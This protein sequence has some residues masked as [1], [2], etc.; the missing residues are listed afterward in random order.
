[1]A[2]GLLAPFEKSLQ[3][4]A[5]R[6]LVRRGVEVRLSTEIRE[7]TRDCVVLAS[8]EKVPSDVTIWAAGVAA[9][10]VAGRWGLPQGRGGR[11]LTGPD[12]RVHG[13]PRVFAAGDIA[14][15]AGLALPQLA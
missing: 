14:P 13:Q 2:P 15:V 1:M 4:Y 11:I 12:L 9:P 10:T 7:V 5:R 6:E 8:G 3:E